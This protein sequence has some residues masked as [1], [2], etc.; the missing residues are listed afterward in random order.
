MKHTYIFLLLMFSCSPSADNLLT[1]DQQLFISVIQEIETGGHPDPVNA[2]GLHFE[3]GPLQITEAFFIDG[4]EYTPT[5]VGKFDDVR[6][7]EFATR[8]VDSY[9]Q[10]YAPKQW[11]DPLNNV[12]YLASIYNGGPTGPSKNA[13]KPYVKRFN[14]LLK[15]RRNK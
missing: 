3:R 15:L 7:I 10:R 4:M 5:I 8:I 13:V 1:P 14:K 2:N 6:D 12:D 9:F 11:I